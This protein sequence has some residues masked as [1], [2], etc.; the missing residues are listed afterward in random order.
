[1][2]SHEVFSSHHEIS[3]IPPLLHGAAM[4]FAYSDHDRRQTPTEDVALSLAVQLVFELRFRLGC[5]LR[6]VAGD[7]Y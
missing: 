4:P 6:E 5:G 1:M 7:G 3:L 2:D